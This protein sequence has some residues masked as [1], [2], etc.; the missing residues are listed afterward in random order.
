MTAATSMM[1]LG[2]LDPECR[3]SPDGASDRDRATGPFDD[4]AGRRKAKPGPLARRLGGEAPH[5]NGCTR[6]EPTTPC[7]SAGPMRVLVSSRAP[8]AVFNI[9]VKKAKA[10]VSQRS[11]AADQYGS[12]P[13][14]TPP[15]GGEVLASGAGQAAS[16][17]NL[18][19]ELPFTGFPL[20]GAAV[21][22]LGF[23]LLGVVLR[24]RE[25]R[26][27]RAFV[28]AFVLPH[29]LVVREPVRCVSECHV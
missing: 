15:A 8:P 24:R 18:S 20:I 4:G 7:L 28:G 11:P 21:I 23:L 16:Q 12:P 9:R 14:T 26:P 2:E 3:S 27:W 1:T 13:Q 19:G 10:G 22:G 6:L 29:R 17:E 5:A 25:L